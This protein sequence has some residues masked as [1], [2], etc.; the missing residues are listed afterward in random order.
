MDNMHISEKEIEVD[1]HKI[2]ETTWAYVEEHRG[3][4]KIGIVQRRRPSG[5]EVKCE[6]N[7]TWLSMESK[8]YD[9]GYKS[10]SLGIQAGDAKAL[11]KALKKGEGV[12]Y[13]RP[14][15]RN[16]YDWEDR[17]HWGQPTDTVESLK[18]THDGDMIIVKQVNEDNTALCTEESVHFTREEALKTAK[19]IVGLMRWERFMAFDHL[20]NLKLFWIDINRGFNLR[21]PLLSLGL[22]YKKSHYKD[23]SIEFI[24]GH[25]R[26]VITKDSSMRQD[27]NGPM[28]PLCGCGRM[29]KR[30]K[31]G[32]CGCKD[33][34]NALPR[35]HAYDY[36]YDY[37][38]VVRPE[39][40]QNTILTISIRLSKFWV[41]KSDPFFEFK[42]MMRRMKAD[43]QIRANRRERAK[44]RKMQETASNGR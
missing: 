14:A 17:A 28:C 31:C 16:K 21:I 27:L 32:W 1:G 12:A 37:K 35:F 42:Q 38:I 40:N 7:D 13:E 43:G 18:V 10:T 26:R 41:R 2:T 9:A 39:L 15:Q 22:M 30:D 6:A 25:N 20:Y 5:V 4:V 19:L 44:L 29:E 23:R 3:K 24:A 34:V 33:V 36:K 11:A 8:M